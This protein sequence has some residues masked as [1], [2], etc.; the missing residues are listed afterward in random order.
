M[1]IRLMCVVAHPDD[2]SAAFG[3]ALLLAAERGIETYVVCMTD[4]QAAT[5]RGEAK[6]AAELGQ[7]RR[8]EF[9]AACKVL[10]TTKHEVLQYQDGQLEK[11]NFLEATEALVERMRNWQPHVVLTFGGDGGLNTHRDHTMVSAFTTAA[12][13][14][15]GRKSRFPEQLEQG[16]ST[17]LAQKLYYLSYDFLL[18]GSDPL[19]PAPYS[20][21]LDVHCV[22][23]KKRMAFQ[24]HTSQLPVMD[25]IAGA[26][27]KYGDRVFNRELYALAACSTQ[28]A[29]TM[30]TDLFK[31]IVA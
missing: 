26:I 15:A 4:G 11:A 22:A 10:R 14:W 30:E 1:A 25:R 28:K 16:L 20:V 6:S 5:F 23:E 27:K 24:Q 2:E 29:S 19:C 17:H 12:F 9:A 18:E 8:A 21:M 31:E 7:I 3:G 13:H